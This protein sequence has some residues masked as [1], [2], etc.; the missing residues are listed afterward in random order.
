MAEVLSRP[1]DVTCGSVADSASLA[2]CCPAAGRPALPKDGAPK[3]LLSREGPSP[4]APPRG[5][6]AGV[7]GL[8]HAFTGAAE[9]FSELGYLGGG[10]V[11]GPRGDGLGVCLGD[12]PWTC[13]HVHTQVRCMQLYSI[14]LGCYIA[15]T[16]LW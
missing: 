7:I 15:A 5:V 16:R 4:D 13:N 11:T 6:E 10:T 14:R 9:M 3:E 1:D 8:A 12:G 2:G